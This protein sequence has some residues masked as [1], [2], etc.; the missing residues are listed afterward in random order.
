MRL[1]SGPRH[2]PTPPRWP[3]PFLSCQAYTTSYVNAALSTCR[4]CCGGHGYAAVNRLGALRSDHDIFQT[5]EGDNTVLLQQ[6]RAA[7]GCAALGLGLARLG[8]DLPLAVHRARPAA[9]GT[10]V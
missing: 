4:E 3:P 10:H 2:R 8:R 9:G 5:F 7:L 1:G 6:A